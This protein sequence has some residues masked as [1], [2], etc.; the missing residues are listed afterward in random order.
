MLHTVTDIQ[1]FCMHDGPGIRTTV[2]LKGCPLNC[3]WCHNPETKSEKTQL[4]YHSAKCIMCGAC[5]ACKNGAHYKKDDKHVFDPQNCIACGKCVDMCPTGALSVA[6]KSM[7]SREILDIAIRDKA[8]Y[9]NE[10]G[11]TVS[12]GEPML[13]PES[14]L[15]LLT[16]AKSEGLN[17]AVETCGYFP[18]EYVKRL[19]AVTDWLLWDVKDTDNERHIKNTGVSNELILKNLRLANSFGAKII[20]RCVILKGV[21]LNDEHINNI[22]ALYKELQNT[23]HVDLLPCHSLGNSKLQALGKIPVELGKFE[24]DEKDREYLKSIKFEK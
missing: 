21:N 13:N 6:G 23:V 7:S 3:F 16:L 17:T 4:L 14:T 24:P 18:T 8:F 22:K 10:G 5:F 15:E 20:L 1:R 19:C 12:G 11:I 2:F 9:G